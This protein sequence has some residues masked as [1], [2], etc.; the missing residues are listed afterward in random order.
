MASIRSLKKDINFLTSELILQAYTNQILF[1]KPE[2]ELEEEVIKAIDYRNDLFNRLKPD[3]K[4]KKAIRQHY[5][6]L[7]ADM[8]D[9]FKK[10]YEVEKSK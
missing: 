10:L 4:E 9:N 8:I 6:K 3:V 1:D 2:K 7:R 5:S